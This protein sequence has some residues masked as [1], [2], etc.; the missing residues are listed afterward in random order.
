MAAPAPAGPSISAG[1]PRSPRPIAGE[2]PA[3]LEAWF[4][5]ERPQPDPDHFE[6]AL[7]L[8]GAQSA[9]CYLGGVMDFLF[10]ALDAWHQARQESPE[11]VPNHKVTVKVIVGASAGGLTSALSAIAAPHRF[12]PASE[13]A[14]EKS[15]AN[16]S[17]PFYRAWVR[18]IDITDLLTLDDIAEGRPVQSALNA[19]YLATRVADYLDFT[20]DGPAVAAHRSWLA[21]PLPVSLTVANL[22]GVNYA[23]Q[24]TQNPGAGGGPEG[25]HA[26]CLHRDQLSFQRPVFAVGGAKA[27]PDHEALVPR[28]S[29]ADAG[30]QRLGDAALASIAF[31]GALS[32]RIV[33]RPNTDYDYRFVFFRDHQLISLTQFPVVDPCQLRFLALDGGLL[34]N[35]PFDIA[36]VVLA[37]SEGRN[38]REGFS[39]RRAVVLIDP[40]VSPRISEAPEKPSLLALPG[41]LY[42]AFT[43]QARFKPIDLALAESGT[44]YSR[45]MIAPVRRKGERSLLGDRALAS[46]RLDAF[47]GY[48]SKHYRHHDFM[49]G[50]R[51]CQ[52]FLRNWF[53][54]PSV[55]ALTGGEGPSN[56][57]FDHWPAPALADPA[58][59]PI[60]LP[61]HRVIIPLVGSAAARIPAPDWP[62]GKFGG[63]EAVAGP[64]GQR[65]DAVFARVRAATL[66]RLVPN[67]LLRPIAGVV[68]RL[69]W[70][71]HARRRLLA[72][73]GR[74]VDA[75]TADID[76]DE[77]P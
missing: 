20:G 18:D 60:D 2:A 47:A 69:Y 43:Q 75:M 50:R 74:Q 51:N 8:A 71:F 35:E 46:A 55:S 3:D 68:V 24:F 64:M 45:F 33:E 58:F 66:L 61:G 6:I 56:P 44:V 7:V 54:L 67:M 52:S 70:R 42:R 39:A 26:M 49:L 21:D 59:V 17:S 13:V 30:W 27:I 32:S 25:G 15:E 12:R 31:P 19:Q 48:F 57:L 1:S 9:G 65:I 63:W 72:S 34:N 23:V 5:R 77:W 41:L 73:I 37:G 28:N 38:L 10:E 62:A 76:K 11:S 40:F 22:V 53:C 4:P 29:A 16:A 14:F 36:H